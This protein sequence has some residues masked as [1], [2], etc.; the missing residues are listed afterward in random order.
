MTS[1]LFPEKKKKKK[2]KKKQVHVLSKPLI[3]Q[4]GTILTTP[5]LRPR[6]TK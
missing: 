6:K 5:C 4:N 2:K 1:C 3:L